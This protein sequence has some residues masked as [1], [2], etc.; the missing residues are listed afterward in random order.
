MTDQGGNAI[1]ALRKAVIDQKKANLP[2]EPEDPAL[3]ELHQAVV[4][5]DQI[6]SQAVIAVI[7]GLESSVSPMDISAAKDSAES[8]LQ[9][10]QVQASRKLAFYQTYKSRLDHMVILADAMGKKGSE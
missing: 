1:N 10:P 9:A 3:M 4:A 2:Y 5:Y 7:Q 8:H 6:V